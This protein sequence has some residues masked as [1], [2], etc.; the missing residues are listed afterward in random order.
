MQMLQSLI[1]IETPG[2]RGTGCTL[3]SAIATGLAQGMTIGSAV[4]RATEHVLYRL[5]FGNSK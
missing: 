2:L 3:G 1:R 4:A 5:R